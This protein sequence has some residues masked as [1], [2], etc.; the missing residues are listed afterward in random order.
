[1]STNGTRHFL[2]LIDPAAQPPIAALHQFQP[3]FAR[4][5]Q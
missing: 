1:M 5:G 2:D 3:C 4:L